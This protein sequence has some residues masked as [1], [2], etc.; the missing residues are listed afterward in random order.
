MSIFRC[1]AA[2]HARAWFGLFCVLALLVSGLRGAHAAEGPPKPADLYIRVAP[3]TVNLHDRT[4]FLQI[5]MTL[6]VSGP[7]LVKPV[8]ENMPVI[9]N[10][11]NYLLSDKDAEQFKSAAGKQVL[12]RQARDVINRALSM[13]PGNGVAE[14]FLESLVVQ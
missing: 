11:L 5:T 8:K 10:E 13:S 3:M 12:A 4:L 2:Q 14:V 9:L 1:F 7:L 6:K